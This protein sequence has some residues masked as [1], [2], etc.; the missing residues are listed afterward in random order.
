VILRPEMVEHEMRALPITAKPRGGGWYDGEVFFS[1]LGRWELQV[2]IRRR[3]EED[4]VARFALNLGDFGFAQIDP[5][6]QSGT[7]LSLQAAWAGQSTRRQL[8]IGGGLALGA[9]VLAGLGAWRRRWIE[10]AVASGLVVVGVL[11]VYPAL[12]IDTTPVTLRKNPIPTDAKSLE[13]GRALY[14]ENCATCHGA[15]GKP[16]L[17]ELPGSLRLYAV[18]LDLTA[19]HMAQH[20][21]GDLFWWIGRGITGTPMPGFGDSLS[22]EERWHLVNYI[23]SL[24]ERKGL[25]TQD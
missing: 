20:T 18:N 24:R 15:G 9:S 6:R 4:A 11:Y 16:S 23:R 12:V 3:G 22:E 17:Q 7:R 14:Q 10:V 5:T 1:M 13:A 21:D 19:D 8:L 25:R 2:V